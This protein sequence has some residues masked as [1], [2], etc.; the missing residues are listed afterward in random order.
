MRRPINPAR[1]LKFAGLIAVVFTTPA[2]AE[3]TQQTMVAGNARFQVLSANVI[4][5]EYSST[6]KFVDAPSVAVQ[7]RRSQETEFSPRQSG[8]WLEITTPRMQL[9]YRMVSGGFAPNN[10]SISWSDDD[11]RHTWKPGDKDDKNLGGVPGDIAL[12]TIPGKEPGPL[13]RNGYFLLDDSHTAVWNATRDWVEPRADR[14]EQDWYFFVYGH[15]YKRALH[16]LMQLLGTIPM[17]PRYI[18]GTWFGSRTGYSA[19]EWKRIIR[20]FREEHVPLD[21]I[22][23]DSDSTAKIIW[24]G[25]DW[26]PEQMPDPAAFFNYAQSQG[27]KVV[28]NEHYGALTAENCSNFERI[29]T[30]IGLPAGTKEIRHDLADKKYAELYMDVLDKPALQQGMAF[31]W[32]DGNASANMPGLDPT[33]WTR[34][35]EYVGTEKI[36]GRRAFDF[37]RL[38]VPYQKTNA[39]PAWGGHRYGGFF[40]GDLAAHWP[41]LNLLI[42]FNVQ[43][44][45]MLIPYVINDNPGFTP[46]VVDTELYERSVQFNALSPV[47]WWHG[48]WGIRMPWEY[49]TQALTIATQFLRLRY[50][51]IPYLYTYSRIA[52]ETGEPI[53]RGTYLEYPEQ[54]GAYDFRHQFLLG[55]E[56]LIAPISEPGLGRPVMKQI[57]LPAGEQWIDWFTGKIYDGGQVIAY[58]CPLERMPIFVK[59]GT[60]LPRAPEMDYSDQRPT[61]PLTLDIFAGKPASFR[62]YEDDGISLAFRKDEY[63]WTQ[64]GYE[65]SAAG[66]H[67]ITI[68]ETQGRYQDQPEKRAYRIR[69]H[70]LLRPAVIRLGSQELPES[71]K[72]DSDGTWRWDDQQQVT[73]I[74]LP[75]TPIRAPLT[76]TLQGS[77]TFA[78][79]KMLE[80]VLEFRAGIRDIEVAEKVKWGALLKGEDIKKEPR[81]LR[82]TEQVE[83][84]LNDLLDHQE[85]IEWARPDFQSWTLR[86]ATAFVDH[87][88]ESNRTIPEMD[89]GAIKSTHA[90]EHASFSSQELNNMTARLLGCVLSGKATGDTTPELIARAD[91][92]FANVRNSDVTYAVSFPEDAGGRWVEVSRTQDEYGYLHVVIQAPSPLTPGVH[93]L[94]M[95]ATFE[96]DGTETRLVRDVPWIV[97]GDTGS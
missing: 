32:Q 49:G 47:F 64:F 13:S 42:P 15:D 75:S 90:I 84:E 87:P 12:R 59:A 95:S 19:D 44:G 31:W 54:E 36:T 93:V 37:E 1:V 50:T 80:K 5:L 97:P 43:A 18:F 16:Q 21:V 40:T 2:L 30:A 72:G 57:Y 11:G 82:E 14:D 94:R 92:Q 56:L 66:E 22:T 91:C 86:I 17:V 74:T 96:H 51:L 33:L 65:P 29:R 20:R 78:A 76:V 68:G 85:A 6:K 60:I 23:L 53:V 81:V 34:H 63:A 52:Y 10:L 79:R 24:A 9:R 25:R 89:V 28:V 77:G 73:T 58:E 3:L 46:Q 62:L 69:V 4:R 27:V 67:T 48:I 38:D 41:T 70:G 7:N 45:N 83:Q 88:F 35:V 61:D 55:K 26:D 39:T 8:G 71:T